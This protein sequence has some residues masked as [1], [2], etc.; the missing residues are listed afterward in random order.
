[1][2]SC[3]LLHTLQQQIE[4]L[5][6][7]NEELKWSHFGILSPAA[8]RRA[9]RQ[10]TGPKDVIVADIRKMNKLNPVIGYSRNNELVG[11]LVCCRSQPG[12]DADIAGVWGGDEVV[13][14]VDPGCGVGFLRR[15]LK[16]AAD[17]TLTKLTPDQRQRL[18]DETQ[19][20]IRGYNLA[21]VLIENVTDILQAVKLG[22][23]ATGTLKEGRKTNNRDTCGKPG[24]QLARLRMAA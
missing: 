21:A 17:V 5:K 20:I 14:V 13:Y 2:T 10:I 18:Y 11:E 19:G 9:I 1:M 3:T 12:R 22:V 16:Q 6:A 7:E 15:L 23:D 8:T 24:T 4:E